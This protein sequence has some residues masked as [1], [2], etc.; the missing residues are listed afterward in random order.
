MTISTE[1]N[2][3]PIPVCNRNRSLASNDLNGNI[4]SS[5]GNAVFLKQVYVQD[6]KHVLKLYDSSKQQ[7]VENVVYPHSFVIH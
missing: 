1:L 4:P 7:G 6:T 2:S 3:S 5:L